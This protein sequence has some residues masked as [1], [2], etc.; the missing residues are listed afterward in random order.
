MKIWDR[1][2]L[3]EL[4]FYVMATSMRRAAE[5]VRLQYW[6]HVFGWSIGR[7]VRVHWSVAIPRRLRVGLG[8][9][10][11]IGA[12]TVIHAET[13]GGALIIGENSKVDV[14][15]QLDA[16]GVL[17]IGRDVTLSSGVAIYTH[18]H[19]SDPRMAPK[20]YGMT[21][22]DGVWL[23]SMAMVLSSA[24]TVGAGSVVGPYAVVREP[25]P[26][27]ATVV[28]ATTLLPAGQRCDAHLHA[29]RTGRGS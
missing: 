17:T 3:L 14:Q 16:S 13:T 18:S 23:C 11:A 24:R 15:C 4:P 6:R 10:V 7:G 27:G 26:A 20:P 25:V 19:G 21:I 5:R 9:D 28:T 22:E 1:H 8:D 2:G 12:G 29:T